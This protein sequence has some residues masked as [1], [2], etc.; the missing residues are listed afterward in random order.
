LFVD[1][2]QGF[3]HEKAAHAAALNL[4]IGDEQEEGTSGES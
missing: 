3:I 1:E 2:R 4:G